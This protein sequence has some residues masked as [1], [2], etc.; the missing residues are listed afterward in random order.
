MAMKTGRARTMQDVEVR[1]KRMGLAGA[2][3]GTRMMIQLFESDKRM[4]RMVELSEG[5]S[6]ERAVL[7]E[8]ERRQAILEKAGL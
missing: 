7:R 6:M 5:L 3:K 4:G 2:I 1:V 8:L